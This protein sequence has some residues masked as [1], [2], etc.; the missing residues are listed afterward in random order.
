MSQTFMSEP[1]R[2]VPV[3]GDYEVVVL[4]GGP[5][6]IAAALAAGRTGRST[7]LIERYG[8]LGGA[9]TA[10]GLSTFC[11]L[12]SNIYGEHK[13][14]ARGLVV[15]IL[16]RLAAMDALSKPHLS[17]QQRIQAQAYDISAYK[18][19]CDEMMAA[20]NVT[21]LYHAFG[22]AVQMRSDTEIEALFVE[23]KEG[24]VA[25]RGRIFI[26]GSGDGDLAAW[27][28][29][30]YEIGDG[31]GGMLYPST[32]FRIN[33]VDPQKAGSA[34]EKIPVL[35]EEAEKKGRKFP[36]KKPIVR[37]QPNPIEWRANL[38]QIKNPDGSAVSG[39]DARQLSYGEVQGRRQCWDVF[40]FIKEVT[41]GFEKAYIVEIA[42]QIGIRETR[43]VRGD[44]MLT[45]EDI[46]ECRDFS[47]SIGVNGWPVEAHEF[48][49]VRFV[50]AAMGSR[51]FN[52]IPYR[53]ILPQKIENLFVTGRCASM[54]HEAQSS[55][56]VSGPCFIMGEAAGIAADLALSAGVAPRKVDVAALQ[57]KLE[58]AGAFLGMSELVEA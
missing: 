7:L 25:V 55:A 56:R 32:M 3:F 51:G 47:D 45:V 39:I 15:E 20:A 8:F 54:T 27:A 43:R 52:Q 10:A 50:F 28:G 29:A 30:P 11:G 16:D 48:G 5:A 2:K 23:T 36:R 41:P 19:V 57:K 18:I 9:G 14:T 44:Y 53:I 37:P 46:L 31:Q 42:P 49:D 13:L 12:H 34:W 58:A 4:G 24:R 38:T 40:E 35:M 21:V 6:G 26:D 22:S 33:G 17:V 1:A